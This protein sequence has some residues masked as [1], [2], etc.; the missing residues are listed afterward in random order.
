M[1]E[2]EIEMEKKQSSAIPLL[3]MVGLIVGLVAVAVYFLAESRKVLAPAEATTIVE[4][5]LKIQGPTTVSFHTGS[6][7]ERYDENAHDARYKLL[8]KISVVKIGKTKAEH[9]PVSLTPKGT[10]LLQQ[11]ADVKQSK[12]DDGNVAY[13]V[14]LASR[15]LVQV[16]KITM[17]G[18]ERATVEYSWRWAP[19]ALGEGFDAAGSG[20]TGL[21][22]WD[23]ATLIDKYGA[24]F[25]HEPPTQVTVNLMKTQQGWQ[26]ATE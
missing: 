23:R 15:K 10:E 21:N 14:P 16:S 7:K 5:I 13:V 3:L 2:Q 18:P 12:D 4:N 8:E 22:T 20:L 19:N 26:I 6:V 1:F 25:Y 17:S 11:I 24:R 9:T